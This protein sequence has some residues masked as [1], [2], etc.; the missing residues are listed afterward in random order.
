MNLI[1]AIGFV[2]A[3]IS[4]WVPD[5]LIAETTDIHQG[6]QQVELRAPIISRAS[7][8][9][10]F[11]FIRHQDAVAGVDNSQIPDFEQAV[12][13]G[14]FSATLTNEAGQT[15]KL[16]HSGYTYYRGF[17]GIELSEVEAG[18]GVVRYD[19]LIIDADLPLPE[20]RFVWLDRGGINIRDL[21][22][23]RY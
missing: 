21:Q 20:V 3:G 15:L 23:Y 5:S 2:A 16:E 18:K 14:S 7:G 1:W 22:R 17:S 12:P 4:P 6:T 11:L 13:T 9:R 8:A 10:L 19:S